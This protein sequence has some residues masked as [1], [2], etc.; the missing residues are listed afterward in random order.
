MLL[1]IVILISFI[2]FTSRIGSGQNEVSIAN[3]QMEVELDIEA[4]KVYG[5]TVLNWT[6]PSNNTV[7]YLLFHMYYNAFK[8][9]QSTFMTEGGIPDFLTKNIDQNCGWGWTHISKI[10]D[11]DGN[12]LSSGIHYVQTDDKNTKDQTVL[13]VPLK[14]A[15]APHETITINFTWE[16]KIPQTMPR[17]GY[18]KEYFFMAQWF[19]KVGVYEPAGMRNSRDGGW[20]CHQY[21]SN[22]EY[23][24]DFGNYDVI[25]TVPKKYV[26]ASSGKRIDKKESGD[27]ITYRHQVD[28]VIDFTW[29]VSPHFIEQRD[30][31]KETELIH[32]S[33]AYKADYAERYFPMLKSAMS[34]LEDLLGPYP[35]P[36][37]SIVDPPVHGMF[38]G[39]MEYPTLIS[40]LSFKFLPDGI[41]IP[42]TLITH[43]Y[44]HQYFMQM[45]ATHEVEEPWMDEGLTSYIETRIMDEVLGSETQV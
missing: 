28:K 1:R 45:I 18:N 4:K 29:S 37:L 2:L 20:N 36:T 30:N 43:E 14:S 34:Y 31:Y 22:G 41:K 21:H 33:Y 42:E 3:Y 7:D 44:I 26:L 15:A 35:Y 24:A 9:S 13:K 19:P 8:N 6:N 17:T 11:A 38:T 5:K 39:G 40:T 32:Y 27:K 25:I 16:A 10:S 23:Y 12:D